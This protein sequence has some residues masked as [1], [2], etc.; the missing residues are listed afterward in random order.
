LA[1]ILLASSSNNGNPNKIPILVSFTSPWPLASADFFDV[2]CR[3]A[4]TGDGAF[5]AVTPPIPNGIVSSIQ[6][7]PDAFIVDFL[8]GPTGRFSSY[9]TPTDIKIKRVVAN[10]DT[11]IDASTP[12][13]SNYRTIDVTFATLS[14]STQTELPRHAR[15]VATIPPGTAQA[16]LWVGS[17]SALRWSKGQSTPTLL[18]MA[19]SFV[20]IAAPATSLRVSSTASRSAAR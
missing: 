20:A 5:V 1:E 6:S 19:D 13:S 18:S 16:V 10:A 12:R 2:E 8:M 14:Q 3:N 9:G 15:I 17:S 7:L 11:T 4:D